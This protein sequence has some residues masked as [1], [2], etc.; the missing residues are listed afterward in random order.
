MAKAGQTLK[1]AEFLPYQLSIT[2]NAVSDLISRAYRGRF[3]L[4]I[5]EWRLMAGLG[6]GGGGARG[7]GVAAT[8]MDKGTGQ[9]ASKGPE[10]RG[11]VG[12]APHD[13]RGRSH[14]FVVDGSRAGVMG[15]NRA[16]A[17]TRWG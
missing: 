16:G 2:S 10:G 11:A 1:L 15:R 12:A 14:P 4:K 3:A 13:S 17:G 5:P 8:T 6:G 9:P 7:G